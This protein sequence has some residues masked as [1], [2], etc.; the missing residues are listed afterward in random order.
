MLIHAIKHFARGN[1]SYLGSSDANEFLFNS[2]TDP[3]DILIYNLH[4]TNISI[5]TEQLNISYEKCLQSC[6]NQSKL[7]SIHI[8]TQQEATDTYSI[9][10]TTMDS[11]SS[12]HLTTNK[13]VDHK[14]DHL[15]PILSKAKNI[16]TLIYE[17][18]YISEQSMYLLTKLGKLN[19]LI[20]DNVLVPNQKTY[21]IML[22]N[23][24]A[25]TLVVRLKH[26]L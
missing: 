24:R 13:G 19:L 4:L 2:R 11:L 9:G 8:K 20:L 25:Q 1:I 22:F 6:L 15:L 5:D 17:N 14:C 3:V 21:S 23:I 26:A 7:N 18:G 16:K 10:S 12:V